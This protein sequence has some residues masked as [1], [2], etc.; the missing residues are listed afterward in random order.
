MDGSSILWHYTLALW[1][2]VVVSVLGMA[3]GAWL[4]YRDQSA[5]SG[6]R[7]TSRQE[8]SVLGLKM[9]TASFGASC[10]AS[11]FALAIV[12][13]VYF[14]KGVERKGDLYKVLSG[15]FPEGTISLTSVP[16]DAKQLED[17]LAATAKSEP[18]Q[19]AGTKVYVDPATIRRVQSSTG[20]LAFEVEPRAREQA[21]PG[22]IFRV[23]PVLDEKK[24]T[25]TFTVSGVEEQAP[26]TNYK[27]V[28][29][30]KEGTPFQE[31]VYRPNKK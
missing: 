25:V 10:V 30:F 8:L 13:V 16:P 17:L 26:T 21:A 27:A 7:A 3:F 12:S 11:F 29:N 19:I 20:G 1:V 28:P 6:A 24:Q 14:P 31:P 15:S 5:G 22:L 23:V 18:L 9:K 4:I 2:F